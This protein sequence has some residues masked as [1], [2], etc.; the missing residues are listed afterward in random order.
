[1]P[2]LP[3]PLFTR[4]YK[5]LD[6]STLT[7]DAAVQYNGFIDELG[8]I[9]IRPGEVLAANYLKR[10]DGLYMWPDKN[11]IVSVDN[12]SV[13]LSQVSGET[14][15][16]T[17]NK[18]SVSY[19]AGT[20]TIFCNDTNYVFMA[21][22]GRINYVDQSG[23]VSEISD[24]DAPTGVTHVAFLDGYIL[25]INQTGRFFWSDIPTDT[26]WSSLSFASAEA[27]PDIIRSLFVVQRQIFLIG[28][29]TT[30]I[31]EN[32]GT[33]PFS[34]VP[35][36]LIEMG[37][38]AK[39]SPVK[40]GDSLVWLNHDREFVQITGTNVK[41]ISDRYSKEVQKFDRV[42]DCI[43]GLVKKDGQ[44]YC[45]F[46][47]P[48][49][50]RT[51][52][53]NPVLEDWSDWGN[54]NP[55]SMSW[56][57]YDFRASV[58]DIDTGKTFIGKRDANVIACLSSESRADLLNATDTRA[59]KF[60]R[61]TGHIDHGTSKNKRLEEIRFRAKRG[62]TESITPQIL[63]YRYRNNGNSQWSNIKEINL[64]AVGNTEHHLQITGRGV[65][66]SRQFEISATDNVDIVL[67]NAEADVTVMR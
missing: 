39:Y 22:G 41:L 26:D 10:N 15:V 46:Q 7:D 37:C 56:E 61:R 66:R 9:N 32:D 48:T 38:A 2:T 16:Q 11:F 55:D 23:N 29:V 65:Y 5:N 44:I 52:V 50:N 19:A 51:L 60:L 14:L 24:S 53:Y 17:Y 62:S 21:G 63:M 35:G 6:Q 31:W 1:M 12:G 43:G 18:G 54:W 4:S 34:R 28:T 36:G 3:I 58:R 47:F 45:V 20:I 67:S 49:E 25:A 13:S 27:N 42:D 64:G 33:T 59:F 57:A 30:E 40:F 8:G